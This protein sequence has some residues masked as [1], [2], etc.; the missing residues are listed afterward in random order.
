MCVAINTI[1]GR[2]ILLSFVCIVESDA[3]S[4]LKTSYA[5]AMRMYSTHL[6]PRSLYASDAVQIMLAAP[7]LPMPADMNLGRLATFKIFPV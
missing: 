5:H 2:T 3:L 6:Y 4:A 7:D 1:L